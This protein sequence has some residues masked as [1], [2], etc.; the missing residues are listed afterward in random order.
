M[1]WMGGDFSGLTETG[2]PGT[3]F[4]RSTLD[5][6]M[7]ASDRG[8]IL[9]LLEEDGYILNNIRV[10]M[11]AFSCR[12]KERFEIYAKKCTEC[13]A[14]H[15]IE[16][17]LVDGVYEDCDVAFFEFL[18]KVCNATVSMEAVEAS[19][20]TPKIFRMICEH[21]PSRRTPEM[22]NVAASESKGYVRVLEMLYD[23]KIK[24]D[25]PLINRARY[26]LPASTL[27]ENV[28]SAFGGSRIDK[29]NEGIFECATPKPAKLE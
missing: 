26:S 12:N 20:P 22:V 19:M 14:G 27:A 24:P 1:D 4:S 5:Y 11:G 28:L 9:K 18:V 17:L 23:W 13:E 6:T 8:D 15:L 16:N 7:A 25:V 10:S 21:D 3:T 2:N 29:W